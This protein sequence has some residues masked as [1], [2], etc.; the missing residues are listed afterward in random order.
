MHYEQ[1][2][3]YVTR[4]ISPGGRSLMS[5]G[6]TEGGPIWASADAG[7]FVWFSTFLVHF[8]IWRAFWGFHHVSLRNGI[9]IWS[10]PIRNSG[11]FLEN[12]LFVIAFSSFGSTFSP[13][14]PHLSFALRYNYLSP[15][16]FML[17]RI[18]TSPEVSW[19]LGFGVGGRQII[20][21][22]FLFLFWFLN[23]EWVLGMCFVPI[24][25]WTVF[26]A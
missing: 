11:V 26:Q 23:G 10:S 16:V 25:S 3:R 1:N 5:V 8:L 2:T 24:L 4:D 19:I 12:I 18:F 7:D 14:K 13:S 17:N 22:F 21:F 15:I 6:P 20:F 9:W